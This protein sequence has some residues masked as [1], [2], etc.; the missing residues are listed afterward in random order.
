LERSGK[1]SVEVVV[2]NCIMKSIIY[3]LHKYNQNGQVKDPEMV[4]AC[5]ALG[6]L[7]GGE[8]A[9]RIW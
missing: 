5:N 9:Y 7:G 4:G 6:E 3:T 8:N 2:E 1:K